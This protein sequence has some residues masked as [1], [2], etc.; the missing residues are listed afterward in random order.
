MDENEDDDPEFVS[1][2]F[3]ITVVHSLPLLLVYTSIA[4]VGLLVCLFLFEQWING[5]PGDNRKK[6][7]GDSKPGK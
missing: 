2:H 1:L 5:H 6:N 3:S 7:H 4:F